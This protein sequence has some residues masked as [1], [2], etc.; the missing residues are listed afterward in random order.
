[1]IE[2]GHERY[3]NAGLP[4]ELHAIYNGHT[5][6]EEA[7]QTLD[8]I[9]PDSIVYVE[10][11]R[12]EEL[13]EMEL[14]LLTEELGEDRRLYGKDER[15][16]RAKELIIE[17]YEQVIGRYDGSENDEQRYR[18]T[19]Y[20]GLLAKDCQIV[21]ADFKQDNHIGGHAEIAKK[22]AKLHQSGMK[23]FSKVRKR[24]NPE[25]YL[26]KLE[27]IIVN[28][29]ELQDIREAAAVT[30]I[31]DDVTRIITDPDWF[32]DAPKTNNGKIKAYMAF[33]SLH[34][35]SLTRKLTDVGV[36]VKKYDVVEHGE[37][38]YFDDTFHNFQSNYLRRLSFTA[39]SALTYVVTDFYDPRENEV[40]MAYMY[41]SLDKMNTDRDKAINFCIRCLDIQRKYHASPAEAVVDYIDLIKEYSAETAVEEQWPTGKYPT[42]AQQ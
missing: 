26:N 21:V 11:L 37:G 36:D 19:L 29:R 22:M 7:R 18:D 42:L 40:V 6:V 23:L 24:S 39:I 38:V 20:H 2:A 34:S 17:E 25:T 35:R 32:L 15:Y 27:K 1:M 41:E 4:L 13:P 8:L 33:G 5:T 30:K 31:S 10:G 12:K 9:E 16:Y 3:Q 28:E 14:A